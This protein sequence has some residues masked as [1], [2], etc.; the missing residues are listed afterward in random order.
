MNNK[1]IIVTKHGKLTSNKGML[2]TGKLRLGINP[3]TGL[4]YEVEQSKIQQHGSNNR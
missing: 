1:V 3:F 4:V 2:Y